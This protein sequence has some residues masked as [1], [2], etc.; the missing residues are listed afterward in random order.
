MKSLLLPL[1]LG[2]AIMLHAPAN[3]Q[4]PVGTYPCSMLDKDFEVGISQEGD[5][6]VDGISMDK[7]QRPCGFIIKAKDIEAFRVSLVA[8]KEKYG[9][10]KM[11]AAGQEVKDVFKEMPV[12]TPR[13]SCYFTYGDLFFSLHPK[14]KVYFSVSEG[15]VQALVIAGDLVASSNQFIKTDGVM[16][17]F[18]DES[19][20]DALYALLDPGHIQEE[21][22]RQKDTKDLFK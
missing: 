4:A 8:I 5:A 11:V 6:W 2:A 20:I 22:L 10:W 14:T 17:A 21:L 15:K 3:A 12:T 18:S 13:M 7:V 1:A 9:Q 19:E 16:L